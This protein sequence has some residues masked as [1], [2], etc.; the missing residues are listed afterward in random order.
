MHDGGTMHATIRRYT[1]K[2]TFDRKTIDELKRRMESQFLPRVQDIRGFHSYYA[3]TV[4][5]RELIT[6][7]IFEDASGGTESTR[8]AAEFV[9]ND[10]VRDRLTGPEVL[11]G[12]VLVSKES[13]VPA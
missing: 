10:P 1:V 6:I 3:L 9:K 5:D 12:E 11:E 4:S 7:G 8:R 2:P 13:A